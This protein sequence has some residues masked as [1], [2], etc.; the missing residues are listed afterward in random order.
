VSNG[1]TSFNAHEAPN[2]FAARD[3]SAAA[4]LL[5]LA[6]R[7]LTDE[8]RIPQASG[9]GELTEAVHLLA[10]RLPNQETYR[11]MDA[12]SCKRESPLACRPPFS[13]TRA[14]TLTLL[15]RIGGRIGRVRHISSE[16]IETTVST[17]I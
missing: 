1:S 11:S 15:R 16:M 3:T 2:G 8:P 7:T 13:M 10:A 4:N 9:C 5:A 14:G 6:D 12:K 17:T